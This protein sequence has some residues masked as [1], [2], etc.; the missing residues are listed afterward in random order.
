[1]RRL[2]IDPG[3]HTGW[4]LRQDDLLVSC[5]VFKF[6]VK[7]A[8]GCIRDHQPHSVIIENTYSGNQNSKDKTLTTCLRFQ[9]DAWIVLCELYGIPWKT[10]KALTWRK[11]H[12]FPSAR[13][14]SHDDAKK[15]SIEKAQV[16]AWGVNDE[17][18][19]DAILINFSEDL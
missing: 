17:N 9:I 1:M 6:S 15:L 13:K 14:I 18:T 11:K 16:Y 10:T 12:G 19:A 4:S 5:G 3:Q 7:E 8:R 2:S